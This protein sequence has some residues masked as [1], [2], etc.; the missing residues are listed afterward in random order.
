VLG[1][2]IFSWNFLPANGSA[3]GILVEVNNDMFDIISWDIRMFSVS[4]VVKNKPDDLVLRI[5][6]LYVSPYEEGK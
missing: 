3:G 2:R 6:T 5:T 1:N 4:V